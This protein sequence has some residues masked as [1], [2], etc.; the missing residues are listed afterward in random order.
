MFQLQLCGAEIELYQRHSMPDNS[1]HHRL[2]TR[3]LT[4]RNAMAAVLGL[5]GFAAAPAVAGDS[6]R[7]KIT[8]VLGP[9][10]VTFDYGSGQYTLKIA[11]LD[12]S[13]QAG[14][15][16]KA[17]S[18]LSSLVLNREVRMRL[19]ENEGE[20]E[21]EREVEDGAMLVRLQIVDPAAGHPDVS[22]ELIKAGM[23]RKKTGF[24]FKYG[25]LAAAE[26]QARLARRG[27]WSAQ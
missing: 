11:G 2:T 16:A 4:R 17:Q 24:D 7:G 10:L 18:S 19:V 20:E 3:N 26:T 5:F 25:E 21:G 13:L 1:S 22:I 14:A 6:M 15:P 9:D 8:A 12:T 27:L 23:A